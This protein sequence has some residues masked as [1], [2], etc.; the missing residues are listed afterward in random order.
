MVRGSSGSAILRGT[1]YGT[2]AVLLAAGLWLRFN[3]QIAAT[4]PALAGPGPLTNQFADTL[5][6]RALIELPLVSA[7]SEPG[8]IARMGLPAGDAALLTQA[9]RSGRVRLVKMPLLD[10]SEILPNGTGH[11][12]QVTAGGYTT[13]VQ[14]TRQ[15]VAVALPVGPISQVSFRTLSADGVNIGAMGLSGPV[16]LPAITRGQEID[17]GVVAQ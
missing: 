6:T 1:L 10:A 12:V 17:V 7:A 11:S 4:V 15:P 2:F 9:L 13:L 16:R 5:G 14:L 8:E 3:S